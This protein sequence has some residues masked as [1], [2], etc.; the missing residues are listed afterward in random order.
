MVKFFSPMAGELFERLASSLRVTDCL[1]IQIGKVTDMLGRRA[2]QLQG[3]TKYILNHEG[4]E[5]SNVRRPVDCGATAIK[6]VDL[7]IDWCYFLRFSCKR[8]VKAHA[9]GHSL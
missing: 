6:P 1:I 7:T 4:A 9:Q 8:I 2:S 3:S 5:I